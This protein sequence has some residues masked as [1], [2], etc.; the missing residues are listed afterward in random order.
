[1]WCCIHNTMC[2]YNSHNMPHTHVFDSTPLAKF[3]SYKVMPL[4]RDT[5]I[6]PP[7]LS[8]IT[9]A[10][11]AALH[12]TDVYKK[13][14]AHTYFRIVHHSRLYSRFNEVHWNAQLCL[15][16][17][18]NETWKQASLVECQYR[19]YVYKTAVLFVDV[20]FSCA[21]NLYLRFA[22]ACFQTEEDVC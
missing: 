2:Q 18:V 4:C 20:L 10:W 11:T 12:N 22:C 1:M 3:D 13:K 7:K 15:I 19:P 9:P 17:D 16:C 8:E 5:L 14:L 6:M 21:D